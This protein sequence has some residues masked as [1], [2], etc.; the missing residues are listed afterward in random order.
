MKN[1]LLL[2]VNIVSEECSTKELVLHLLNEL[3]V[4]T[5][6]QLYAYFLLDRPLSLSRFKNLLVELR[7][8]QL[9]QSVSTYK[10]TREQ[11]Y[12]LSKKGRQFINSRYSAFDGT[13]LIELQKAIMLNDVLLR[14]IQWCVRKEVA[15]L[16]LVTHAQVSA[17]SLFDMSEEPSDIDARLLIKWENEAYFFSF[18]VF[19]QWLDFSEGT[20]RIELLSLSLIYGYPERNDIEEK[21]KTSYNEQIRAYPNSCAV[22]LGKNQGITEQLRDYLFD[23]DYSMKGLKDYFL[24]E[25]YQS[26]SLAMYFDQEKK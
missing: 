12:F 19:P 17:D 4:S 25:E 16:S 21:Y 11:A 3:Q 13:Q 8:E 5:T 20:D 10:G 1:P 14:S 26:F 22:V 24:V 9:I 18:Q 2:N 6:K 15:V 7:K 23:I